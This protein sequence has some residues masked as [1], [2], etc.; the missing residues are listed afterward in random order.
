M[1]KAKPG[2]RVKKLLYLHVLPGTGWDEEDH[3]R[4]RRDSESTCRSQMHIL[5]CQGGKWRPLHLPAIGSHG[6]IANTVGSPPDCGR[7]SWINA[8]IYSANMKCVEAIRSGCIPRQR[9]QTLIV[10]TPQVIIPTIHLAIPLHPA[11]YY[12]ASRAVFWM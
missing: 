2:W 4:A 7:H 11:L 12:L 3:L 6:S 5:Y 10:P 8:W 9:P 1:T